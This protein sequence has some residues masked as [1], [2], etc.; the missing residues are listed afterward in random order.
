MLAMYNFLSL[1]VIK[2]TLSNCKVPTVTVFITLATIV[3]VDA[4]LT[5]DT[6]TIAAFRVSRT[7]SRSI[8]RR[9]PCPTTDYMHYHL[10][11]S[12]AQ[13]KIGKTCPY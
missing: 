1:P 8:P 10:M 7:T 13:C 4:C 3:H 6:Y 5:P 11:V 12:C 2:R 9:R